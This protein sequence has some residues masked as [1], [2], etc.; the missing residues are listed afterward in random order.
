MA[1]TVTSLAGD[2]IDIICRRHYGDESGYVEAVMAVNYQ[3]ANTV[4][5]PVGTP[6]FL[7]DIDLGDE[8]NVITLWD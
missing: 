4:F 7:P 2:T 6:V 8:I 1:Q 3:I 5:L